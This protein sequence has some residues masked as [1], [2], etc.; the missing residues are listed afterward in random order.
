MSLPFQAAPLDQAILGPLQATVTNPSALQDI[1]AALSN[2]AASISVGLEPEDHLEDG[3]AEWQ[4]FV[5]L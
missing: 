1:I 3:N 5:D 4:E 2:Q